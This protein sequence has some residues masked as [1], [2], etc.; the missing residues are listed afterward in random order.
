MGAHVSQKTQYVR[1]AASLLI[2]L[3]FCSCKGIGTTATTRQGPHEAGLPE[4]AYTGQGAMEM[5][6]APGSEGYRG[7][8]PCEPI[9]YNGTV[10]LP[11]SLEGDWCPP[12]IK[13][14]WP[15]DEYLCDG[16]DQEIGVTVAP[17]WKVRNLD[18]EDTVA[19]YDTVDGQTLVEPSNRVCLYAPRFAAVR[20][21]TRLVETG[22]RVKAVGTDAPTVPIRQESVD[23]ATTALQ[24]EQLHAQSSRLL[25]EAYRTQA[26]DGEL[27]R[28]LMPGSF[29]DRYKLFE[30][31]AI[32]RTG[33][34]EQADRAR[35]Q[36]GVDAAITW[37]GDQ[38]VRILLDGREAVTVS[39]ARQPSEI[40]TVDEPN[41]PKLRLIKIAS[42]DCAQPGDVVDFTLRFDNVGDQTIGNVVILDNLT[43]RLEYIPGSEQSSV[44]AKFSTELN[45]T[46]SLVLR[47]EL[48]DPLPA[49]DPLHP[50]KDKMGGVI[51]FRC[52]VR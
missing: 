2:S 31:L 35:L 13:R 20:T 44:A 37:S 25:P 16:G 52:K 28:N 30:D 1:L 32:I 45:E 41:N 17:D 8:C 46:G 36:L 11:R 19:H 27:S 48:A 26:K 9:P 21:V 39:S 29:Q 3:S 4:S 43:T 49:F 15:K 12:G 42:T 34:E 38:A 33:Q 14:P 5:T 6:P 7:A 50:E 40:F 18:L 51:R 23:V 24:R 47:W 22:S 10:P